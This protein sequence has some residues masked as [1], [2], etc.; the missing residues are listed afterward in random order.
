[1]TVLVILVH[2]GVAQRGGAEGWRIEAVGPHHEID[3]ESNYNVFGYVKGIKC[4][5]S[6]SGNAFE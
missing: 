6:R 1:M 4:L 5:R 2:R 3:L